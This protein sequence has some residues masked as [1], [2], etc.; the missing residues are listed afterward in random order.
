M[1]CGAAMGGICGVLLGVP[2]L[3]LSGHYLAVTTIGFG[4]IVQLILI[5]W[6]EVTHGSDGIPQIPVLVL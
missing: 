3:K 6:I 2:S 1:L 5:N 4:F